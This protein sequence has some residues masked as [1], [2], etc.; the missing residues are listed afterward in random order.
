MDFSYNSSAQP[1]RGGRNQTKQEIAL[2]LQK[3]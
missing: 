2:I 1:G 3:N